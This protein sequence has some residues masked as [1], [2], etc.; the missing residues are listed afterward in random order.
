MVNDVNFYLANILECFSCLFV[1]VGQGIILEGGNTEGKGN[2][3]NF[4]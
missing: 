4:S 3:E 1:L 2:Y